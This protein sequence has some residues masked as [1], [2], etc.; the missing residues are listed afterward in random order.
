MINATNPVNRLDSASVQVPERARQLITELQQILANAN[1]HSEEIRYEIST[2][3]FTNEAKGVA[4][5]PFA[6]QSR[7]TGG[8]NDFQ[9]I[10]SHPGK[11]G[12][13]IWND[14]DRV[15]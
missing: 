10:M 5:Q 7:P 8:G 11:G 1:G 13:R 3:L 14:D 15:L 9:D 4:R 6:S 12:G 2:R